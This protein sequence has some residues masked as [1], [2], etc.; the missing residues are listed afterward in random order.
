VNGSKPIGQPCLLELRTSKDR[1][2]KPF[3]CTKEKAVSY[4]ACI[5]EADRVGNHRPLVN[6]I[7]TDARS[8]TKAVSKSEDRMEMRVFL[9]CAY[10]N[11][12]RI[13]A[14]ASNMVLLETPQY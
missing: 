13:T 3:T 8:L 2:R 6:G 11:K 12:L 10:A 7:D 14:I 5:T 9:N 1:E 4:M